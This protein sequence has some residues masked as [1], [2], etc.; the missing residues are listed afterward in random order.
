M[1]HAAGPHGPAR[2]DPRRFI[3][4]PIPRRFAPLLFG[5]LLSAIMVAIVSGTV[6]VLNEGLHAGLLGKWLRACATT[7]PVAFPAVTVI[8]PFVRRFVERVTA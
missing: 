2:R 8:S 7:W 6:L 4:M 1:S 5:A 3:A